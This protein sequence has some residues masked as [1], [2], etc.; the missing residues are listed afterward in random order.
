MAEGISVE[1]NIDG[2]EELERNLKLLGPRVA[3]K[4]GAKAAMEG[5]EVIVERAKV[6]APVLTGALEDSITAVKAPS[7]AE[8]SLNVSIGFKPPVSRRAHFTEYGTVH[9]AA[10]PFMRPALD[11]K[12]DEA[13][14]RMGKEIWQGIEKESG[15]LANLPLK[16]KGAK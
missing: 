1:I 5:A 8:R 12:A 9:S 10:Q 4:V 16:K 11:E 7:N 2:F 3:R 15:R 14:A 6:L 13:I